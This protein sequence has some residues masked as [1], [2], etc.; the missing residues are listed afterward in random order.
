M[1]MTAFGGNL[2]SRSCATQAVKTSARI[3]ALNKPMVSRVLPINA[4]MALVQPLAA[5]QSC[6]PTHLCPRQAHSHGC[7]TYH[8][9]SRFHQ[10]KQSGVYRVRKTL[11]G[12]E[13]YPVRRFGLWDVAAFFFIANAQAP[14]R[15]SDPLN[16]YPRRRARSY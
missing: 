16:A 6:V 10:C 15:I 14:Q 7:A 13:R 5:C 9:Q 2:G 8:G 3:L 4:P 1:T 12:S 11:S